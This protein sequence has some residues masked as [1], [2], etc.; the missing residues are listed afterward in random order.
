[1]DKVKK[2]DFV[3]IE[4]TG[5]ANN[6][7]FDT[8]NPKEA[9]KITNNQ[10]LKDIKPVVVSV[11]NGMLLKG[12]DESL[13]EKEIEKEY[14]ITLTPEKA[15][16]K[17]YSDLIKTVPIK[18]FREKNT[19]P[20]P[21]MTIQLDNSIAKVLS[22][23]GG[24]VIVDFNNP[25]AGKEIKYKFKIIKKIENDEERINAMQDFF[26]RQ[27][28]KFKIEEKKVIFEDKKIKYIVDLFNEKLKTIS[29]FDFV[30]EEKEDKEEKNKSKEAK[31]EKDVK[32]EEIKKDDKE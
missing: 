26:F 29:G 10:N 11:G 19:M 5:Y 8:T 25:L 17:R 30:V 14:E 31:K 15:F 13:D 21:G 3:E 23:S 32:S 16:G 22:V 9:A 7:I 2:N 12:F 28:F 18:I 6:K 24:R 1:M 4:F 20:Y 27:R